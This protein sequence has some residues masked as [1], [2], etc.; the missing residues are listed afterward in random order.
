MHI[1]RLVLHKVN[2]LITLWLEAS[3]TCILSLTHPCNSLQKESHKPIIW[4]MTQPSVVAV[5]ELSRRMQDSHCLDPYHTPLKKTPGYN[6][7]AYFP[8]CGGTVEALACV[9]SFPGKGIKP[10]FLSP[11]WL[12]ISV[13][14]RCTESQDFGSRRS[15]PGLSVSVTEENLGV[16]VRY[17]SILAAP[18]NHLKT[19]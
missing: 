5:M 7:S 19:S 6:T 17:F 10:P 16:S 12:C 2:S 4:R 11:S 14:H 1:S 13:R 3:C 8:G 18:E 9:S 15:H